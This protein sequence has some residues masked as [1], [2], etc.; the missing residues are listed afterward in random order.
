MTAEITQNRDA[1]IKNDGAADRG[2]AT[3]LRGLQA[4]LPAKF[5]I[6]AGR[7][8]KSKIRRLF[9][10]DHDNTIHC[11]TGSGTGHIERVVFNEKGEQRR[12]NH[13]GPAHNL[14][15]AGCASD[16]TLAR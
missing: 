16:V 13:S 7:A 15:Y 9:R 3:S 2:G 14:D 8:A 6:R 10:L 11:E 5:P 4:D 1:R 12:G